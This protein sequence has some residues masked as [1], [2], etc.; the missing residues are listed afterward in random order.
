M[1]R[2]EVRDV[3][4]QCDFCAALQYVTAA[5][6]SE[7]PPGWERRRVLGAGGHWLGDAC[8]QCAAKDDASRNAT[9]VENYGGKG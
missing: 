4:F 8:P 9:R 6:G 7:M 2:K 3:L 1:T 5:L